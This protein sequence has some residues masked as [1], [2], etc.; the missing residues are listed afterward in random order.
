[1]IM[2][3]LDEVEETEVVPTEAEE[4]TEGSEEVV[5]EEGEAAAE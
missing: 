5:V 3:I 1:M 4:T 2:I